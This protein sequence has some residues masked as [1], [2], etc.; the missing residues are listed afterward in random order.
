MEEMYGDAK[1]DAIEK[2]VDKV[3]KPRRNRPK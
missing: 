3:P 1:N 2:Q